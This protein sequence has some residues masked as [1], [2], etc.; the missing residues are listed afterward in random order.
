ML[1]LTVPIIPFSALVL[2]PQALFMSSRKIVY[3]GKWGARSV[4]VLIMA[5]VG[6]RPPLTRAPHPNSH[7]SHAGLAGHPKA[8]PQ[9]CKTTTHTGATQGSLDTPRLLLS[10]AKPQLTLEPRR[11]RWTRTA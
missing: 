7:W 9:S 5:Q 4:A 2:D 8:I 1:S 11:A 3:N 6:H 10:P